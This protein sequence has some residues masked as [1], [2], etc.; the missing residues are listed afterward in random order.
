MFLTKS[1]KFVTMKRFLIVAVVLLLVGCIGVERNVTKEIPTTPVGQV[2]M[3][4]LK[5]AIIMKI[6]NDYKALI[7]FEFPNPC[8]RIK[9]EGM[10]IRDNVITIDFRY[11]PPKPNEVCAQVL[12]EYNKTIDLGNLA[13]GTYTILIRVNGSIVKELKFEVK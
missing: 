11:S 1:H 4:Y 5:Q 3:P 9:F 7:F 2:A 12:Q 6:G 13:K 8:H 10:E